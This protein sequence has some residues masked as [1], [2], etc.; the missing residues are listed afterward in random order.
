MYKSSK[1]YANLRF[2]LV[3]Y[4]INHRESSCYAQNI[5]YRT[6]NFSKELIAEHNIDSP[7]LLN[8]LWLML[9]Y[10]SHGQETEVLQVLISILNE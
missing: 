10:L 5:F 8:D 6:I 2:T 7:V 1:K 3:E 4:K 9:E